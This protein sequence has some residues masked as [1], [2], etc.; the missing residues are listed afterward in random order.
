[1]ILAAWSCS[2]AGTSFSPPS[3]SAIRRGCRRPK[4]AYK[5]GADC[6]KLRKVQSL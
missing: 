6:M 5:P 2:C 3:P 4:H 1:M